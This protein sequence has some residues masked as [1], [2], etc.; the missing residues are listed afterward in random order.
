MNVKTS[1]QLVF[2][3]NACETDSRNIY[4]PATI[5]L[6]SNDP[7]LT[8]H[9]RFL[10]FCLM[11]MN[12]NLLSIYAVSECNQADSRIIGAICTQVT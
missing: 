5:E 7:T 9:K 2:L 12:I 4:I 6:T 10:G 3:P 8:L 11:Y 1:F